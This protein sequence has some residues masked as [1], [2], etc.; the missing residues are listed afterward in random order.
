MLKTTLKTLCLT[1]L[2]ISSGALAAD[3]TIIKAGHI[4]NPDTGT[5]TDDRYVVIDGKKIVSISKDL[6]AGEAVDYDLSDH[7]IMPGL[8]DMHTH[9]TWNQ[10]GDLPRSRS[11]YALHP[12]MNSTGFRALEGLKNAQ[13]LLNKGFTTLRDVGNNANY[14]DSDVRKALDQGLF[15][16]P[17]IINAGKIIAP[18]GG[19]THGISPEVG[20]LW[21]QEYVDADSKDELRKAIRQNI[22]Y[23]AK[24]IKLVN[25][26][27]AYRYDYEDLKFA[28]DEV[29]K[30]GLT[31]AVHSNGDAG[32]QDAVQAGADSIEHGWN[33]GAET[34][35]LMAEK[36]TY[37]V[38]TD[39]PYAHMKLIYGPE[40]GKRVVDALKERLA[41]A[42]K[43]KVKLAFGTDTISNI[44]GR[45]R[46]QMALDYIDLWREVGIPPA[47]ILKAMTINPA[48]LM[49]RDDQYGTLETG[50]MADIIASKTNPLDDINAL[51]DLSFV[52]KFGQLVRAK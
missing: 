50:K 9:I 12:P 20:T 38:G 1:T 13:D 36:G 42:W 14:A 46:G 41:M 18:F 44:P 11:S 21:S 43:Y 4:V 52:M 23:G 39:F 15:Q 51:K 16:G 32:T 5:V 8:M 34:L 49:K 22:Y 7:Y 6:P 26:D 29:H 47:G 28:A 45:D 35:K 30:A 25:T 24:L 33:I 48:R 37:L 10:P 31:L 19:Q 17:T 27:Q 2:L 40:R 3:L